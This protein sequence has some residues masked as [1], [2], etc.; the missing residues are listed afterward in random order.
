MNPWPILGR[1]QRIAI[2][3]DGQPIREFVRPRRDDRDQRWC[4]ASG[5]TVWK[6]EHNRIRSADLLA[7]LG[8]SIGSG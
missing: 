1:A 5:Q 8:E 3:S 7:A 6:D 2:V 4:Q